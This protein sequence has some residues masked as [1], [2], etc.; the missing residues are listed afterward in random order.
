MRAVVRGESGGVRVAHVPDPTIEEPTDAVVR[1]ALASVCGTDL[2]GYHG[3]AAIPPGPRAGHEFLGVVEEGGR[4]VGQ[5]RRRDLV[6]A[7]FLWAD[8]TCVPSLCT[9]RPA[10]SSTGC[11]AAAVS[12]GPSPSPRPTAA[13]ASAESPNSTTSQAS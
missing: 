3:E 6:L 12:A 9:T 8:G 11:A 10:A 1:V 13:C 4:E 7:P 2:W 5:L